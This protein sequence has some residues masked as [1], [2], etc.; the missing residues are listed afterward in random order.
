MSHKVL[1]TGGAGYIGS[2]LVP[3]LLDRGYSVTVVDNLSF[4]QTT[5]LESCINHKFSFVKGDISDQSLME[6][7]LPKHDI[8]IPLAAIVG[9]PACAK[10]PA[11]TKLINKD[12]PL[13]MLKHLSLEQ[14]ILFP[15]TNS[16]YGV[17]DP[18]KLCDENSPLRP[19]S[20][21]ART[22]VEIEDAVLQSGNAIT[23]RLATVF[24]MSPRMRMDLLVNDF[25]YR[26]LVDKYVVL[27]EEN[28]RRNYIH[29]RDVVR[30]FIFGISHFEEM[31]GQPY[32]T[33]LSDANLTKRQLCENIKQHITEL[34]IFVSDFGKDPD[35]RDYLVSNERIE[36]FGWRPEYNLDDGIRE[37]I[38]GYQLLRPNVY[39]NN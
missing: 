5:L 9:A 4:G 10:N 17:G 2:M 29:V 18:G 14:Q 6:R 27:F 35:K 37:L 23:F 21:Y 30:A 16:G 19:L 34:N 12:A 22:K 20:E 38:K 15:T 33:G 28:F 3:S 26:S 11:L 13:H 36:S 32:N 8:I 39:T 25:V 7:L 1:V 24:G 31:K